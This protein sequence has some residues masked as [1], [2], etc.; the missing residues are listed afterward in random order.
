[1]AGPWTMTNFV[2]LFYNIATRHPAKTVSLLLKNCMG[3]LSKI[4]CQHITVPSHKSGSARHRKQKNKL[5]RHHTLQKSFTTHMPTLCQT[6]RLG[7]M[8]L[9]RTL[10]PNSG[11]SMGPLQT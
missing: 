8:W 9:Y 2:V 10:S 3:T 6:Y 7:H 4:Y 5:N 11:I 1:M